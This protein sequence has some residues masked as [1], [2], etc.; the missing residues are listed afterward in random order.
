MVEILSV[1]Y[2]ENLFVHEGPLRAA[3]NTFFGHGGPLRVTEN[4]FS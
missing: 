1:G 4:T 3:K 2:E